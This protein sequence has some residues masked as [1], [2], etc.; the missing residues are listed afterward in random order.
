[1]KARRTIST[2][3][4]VALTALSGGAL[5][6]SAF[7]QEIRFYP[8][9]SAS[10]GSPAGTVGDPVTPVFNPDLNGGAGCWEVVVGTG[11]EVDIDLQGSGW[12]NA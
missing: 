6:T 2:L 5:V 4:I 7:A 10:V 9:R 11:T 3:A 12:G 8:I 1:M